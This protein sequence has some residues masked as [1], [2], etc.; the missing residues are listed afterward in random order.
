M[1][2]LL[3]IVALLAIAAGATRSLAQTVPLHLAVETL[4]SR[5]NSIRNW[6]AE[7]TQIY[8]SGLQTRTESGRLYLQK[9]GRMRWDYSD[10]VHK[11]FL[12]AQ[13]RV[14]QYAQ[15]G[16]EAT[17]TKVQN[18]SDLRTPLRF[19]LGHTELAKELNE[20]SFSG[21]EPWHKGDMVIHG[22]PKQAVGEA[23]W[24]ELWIEFT[25][26]YR[27]VRLL[28]LGLDG[29]QNDLR[30]SGIRVNMRL[31]GGIFDFKPPAGVKVIPGGG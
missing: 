5:Y 6:E 8:T 9:P 2:R 17:V 3:S 15:G 12:V 25:P 24:R 28:I 22:V 14:F 23:G 27:I 20:L 19:L 16:N 31:P 11:V 13:N 4:D 18:L 7:F 30:F 1:R 26:Q 10:P 21:L 29:S